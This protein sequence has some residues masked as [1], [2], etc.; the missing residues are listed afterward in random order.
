[1]RL[2]MI[3]LVKNVIVEE[4]SKPLDKGYVSPKSYMQKVIKN[5]KKR[6][7]GSTRG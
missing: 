5:A 2:Q 6:K 3:F 4:K 7:C 1:M